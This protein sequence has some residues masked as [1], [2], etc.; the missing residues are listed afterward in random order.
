RC[1]PWRERNG[2]RPTVAW[3]IEICPAGVRGDEQN[4]IPRGRDQRLSRYSAQSHSPRTV[5][6]VEAELSTSYKQSC[7]AINGHCGRRSGAG[8]THGRG[9]DTCGAEVA[10]RK[11][12]FTL[13]QIASC[14]PKAMPS[15]PIIG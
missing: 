12:K 11:A 15:N 5:A 14:D 7:L 13:L 10:E 6:A 4:Q 8:Q 3:R 2:N 1:F 9:L